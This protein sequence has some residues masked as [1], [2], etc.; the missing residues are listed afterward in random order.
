MK[1][2]T[3]KHKE[4]GPD[5]SLSQR[6]L[7]GLCQVNYCAILSLTWYHTSKCFEIFPCFLSFCV[8]CVWQNR[9]YLPDKMS[10]QIIQQ[11]TCSKVTHQFLLTPVLFLPLCCGSALTALA[12]CPVV[13]CEWSL[14]KAQ[15]SHH[16]L[17]PRLLSLRVYNWTLSPSSK[18]LSVDSL[19]LD[20]SFLLSQILPNS[21]LCAVWW[22]I[23]LFFPAAGSDML[24]FISQRNGVTCNH[25]ALGFEKNLRFH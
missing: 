4:N 24:L 23:H 2:E 5:L 1:N 19:S 9:T 20:P 14:C 8:F 25:E 10:H 15:H 17:P 18:S 12:P 6:C 7:F 3:W 22:R 13:I 11:L 21:W 16:C